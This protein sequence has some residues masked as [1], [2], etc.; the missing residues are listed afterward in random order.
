MKLISEGLNRYRIARQP[1]MKVDAVVFVSPALVSYLDEDKALEQLVHAAQL[2]GVVDPVIGM[3]DIHEGFGL[4]IGGVMASTADGIIS[5]GA[6]GMDI[7]CGV[8]LVRSSLPARAFDRPVLRQIMKKIEEYVPTGVG[9][10]GRHK[11][12]TREIFERVVHTGVKG[13]IE[14]GFGESRDLEY[15]EENGFLAGADLGAVSREA[16]ARGAGQLG[17]L[18]GGNHFIEIQEVTE[19]Y[20]QALADAFGLFRGQLTVMIHTGSRGFG[21]QICTDYS[22]S[23]LQAAEKYK[24][25]LPS[26]GLAC[27]PVNSQEGKDYYAAMACAVNFAFSNRQIIMHDIIQAFSDVLGES[28][29]SLGMRLVYDVAHNIAKWEDHRGSRLLVHRKGATRAL[30]AGH[31]DNPPAFART[32]HPALIPGSMGT[33]SYVLVGTPKAKETFFSVNHGAGRTLSR[34]AAAKTITKEQFEESMGEVLYNSRNYKELVDEAPPAYKD[35]EEV[36]DTLASLDITRKV[37]R[38]RPLAVIKGKD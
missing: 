27:A 37:A 29:R 11:G 3:P 16:V 4:P 12:I 10:K 30:P 35:I 22:K 32:G 26:K 1:G 13:V 20:D 15:I 14:Q 9:K 8:R 18:G 38:L 25:N 24:L 2:P 17:T 34:N 33:A 31:P 6:V 7:N 19:I 5:A 23:L 21:H 36:V 28:P